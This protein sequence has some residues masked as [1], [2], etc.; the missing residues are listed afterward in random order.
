MPQ[1]VLGEIPSERPTS[2]LEAPQLNRVYTLFLFPGD[3][4][5]FRLFEGLGGVG[6]IVE[7]GGSKNY[8][9]EN[10]A[11]RVKWCGV[12]GFFVT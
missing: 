5:F 11:S 12:C 2:R 6:A 7:C 4:C 10:D 1:T 3:V 8:R 9:D